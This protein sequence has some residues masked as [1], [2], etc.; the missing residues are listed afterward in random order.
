VPTKIGG[1]ES[2]AILVN[3]NFG[4]PWEIAVGA[5]NLMRFEPFIEYEVSAP[6]AARLMEEAGHAVKAAMEQYEAEANEYV[7]RMNSDKPGDQMR[8]RRFVDASGEPRTKLW[9]YP[10]LVRLDDKESHALL[11]KAKSDAAKP[12]EVPKPA[13]LVSL[14]RPTMEWD[15]AKLKAYLKDNGSTLDSQKQTALFME[16]LKL[17][18]AQAKALRQAGMTVDEGDGV[19]GAQASA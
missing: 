18:N 3:L 15:T 10:P 19:L 9:A 5:G 11:A 14:P 2:N 1:T 6:L 8:A 13:N 16:A 4:R 7:T 12:V 17:H